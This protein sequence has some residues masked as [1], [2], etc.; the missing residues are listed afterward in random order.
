MDTGAPVCVVAVFGVERG[1]LSLR[2]RVLLT[3][4]LRDY[5][6][7]T[8]RVSWGVPCC[9]LGLSLRRRVFLTLCLRDYFVLT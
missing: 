2:R 7:L 8:K 4:C 1:E 3:L 6:V 5:F 9:S